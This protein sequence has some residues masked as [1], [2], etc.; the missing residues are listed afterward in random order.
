[1]A[2]P[3]LQAALEAAEAAS[4]VVRDL[5]RR[6]LAITTKADRSPVTEADVLA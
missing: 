5:Y 3:E 2:S 6:N 4:V 1:M